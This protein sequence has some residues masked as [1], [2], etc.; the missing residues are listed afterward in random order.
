MNGQYVEGQIS[1]QAVRQGI[2]RPPSV[3]LH[4]FPIASYHRFLF[5]SAPPL[6]LSLSR[7]GLWTSNELL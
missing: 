2:S 3:S 5:P 1:F 7:K 6:D 4:L